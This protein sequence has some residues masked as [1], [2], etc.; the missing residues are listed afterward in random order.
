MNTDKKTEE[1]VPIVPC[2]S[3]GDGNTKHPPFKK[4]ISPSK[5]WCFTLN[6]YNKEDIIEISSNSSI[7]RYV[8]QEE[9]GENGTPHLQGYIEFIK[10]VRPISVIKYTTIHWEKCR[11]IK[12][13][14]AYCSK[15]DTRTGK[16][17]TN[18]KIPKKIKIIE[19]LYDWQSHIVDLIKKEPD[20][21][22]IHWF[23]ESQGNK[24]KSALCKYLVVKH[25][26]VIVSGKGS[27]VKYMI[28]KYHE[29]HGV[30]PEIIIYDIPRT[31]ENYISY[32]AIE[33]IKNGLFASSK[34]ECEMVVMNS[35]HIICFA[36]FEPNYSSM[37]L[38][39]WKV[40]EL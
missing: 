10:K 38:D 18:I 33:E 29:K 11:N 4:Q 2:S 17:Y 31:I 30:Y 1:I 8:F 24:G 7:K 3:K 34:Y 6:N 16:I 28:V 36:N 22:T 15:E 13:S 39:R 14:I 32:T 37:S 20:D 26:A 27:D 5:H 9:T 40:K 23:W 35:P 12:A 21:R 25:D 19:N